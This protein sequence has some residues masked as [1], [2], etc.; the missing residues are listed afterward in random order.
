MSRKLG[1]SVLGAT[2]FALLL[3]CAAVPAQAENEAQKKAM[4]EL[5]QA[6]KS[7]GDAYTAKDMDKFMSFFADDVVGAWT[8]DVVRDK[9]GV[10]EMWTGRWKDP[11]FKF[12]GGKRERFVISEAGD[13]AYMQGHSSFQHTRNG[14]PLVEKGS[15]IT[16]WHKRGGQWKIVYDSFNLIETEKGAAKPQ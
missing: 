14:E 5:D 11:G 4:E 10:R 9:Q 8:G 7:F 13:L 12:I 15:W 16:L 6:D 3:A 1:T 2:I